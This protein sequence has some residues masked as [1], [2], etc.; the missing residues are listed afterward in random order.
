MQTGHFNFGFRVNFM[1]TYYR[2]IWFWLRWAIWLLMILAVVCIAPLSKK[3]PVGG[4]IMSVIMGGLFL[5]FLYLLLKKEA[6]AIRVYADRFEVCYAFT[7]QTYAYASISEI[8]LDVVHTRKSGDIDIV[9]VNFKSGRTMGL[10]S[11]NNRRKL[12]EDLHECWR[13]GR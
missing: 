5:F 13:T 12:F 2:S 9:R 8:Y 10:G 6:Y 3:T 7:R 4:I 11:L 1:R